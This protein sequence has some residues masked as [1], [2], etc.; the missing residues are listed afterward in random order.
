MTKH[1]I[2]K[3]GME[4]W[5]DDETNLHRDNGLPAM[6]FLDGGEMYYQHGL[7]HRDNGPAVK[8]AER[9]HVEKEYW[10]HGKQV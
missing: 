3:D 1:L 10:L 9:H 6:V 2:G 8:Y 4:F 5:Y 7:L